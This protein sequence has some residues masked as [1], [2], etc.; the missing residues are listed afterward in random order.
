LSEAEGYFSPV[1]QKPEKNTLERSG[2]KAKVGK[3]RRNDGAQAGVDSD[4]DEERGGDGIH[5]GQGDGAQPYRAGRATPCG[6]D[7][8]E[9][10]R[11]TAP[12]EPA[13]AALGAGRLRGRERSMTLEPQ[14]A[15]EG[16][17]GRADFNSAGACGGRI[18]I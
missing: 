2:T 14:G 5:G 18:K 15:R 7:R 3:G 8:S 16:R 13:E 11:S 9:S 6:A 12:L 17:S 1:T 4:G 10:C